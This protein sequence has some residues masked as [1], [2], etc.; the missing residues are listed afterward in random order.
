MT[1]MDSLIKQLTPITFMLIM[2]GCTSSPTNN[3][4]LID[5]NAGSLS[6]PITSE[7]EHNL[8]SF[9]RAWAGVPINLEETV[10]MV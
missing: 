3:E 8:L 2:L 4:H 10:D 5:T 9:Y 7:L 6:S 1:N